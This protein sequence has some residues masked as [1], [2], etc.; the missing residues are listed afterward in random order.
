MDCPVV[1]KPTGSNTKRCTACRRQRHLD[2]CKE[3][4]KRTYVKKGRADQSGEKNPG[5][6]GGT[7]PAYYRKVGFEAHG[8]SCAC[9]AEAVLIHHKDEDRSNSNPS[10]LVPLCKRCHQ[11]LH[12]CAAN[13][14]RR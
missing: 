13:L 4:W 8:K 1:F 7:S 9:G 10:N 3:R 12:N 6:A 5:W 2:S 11:L 14:P